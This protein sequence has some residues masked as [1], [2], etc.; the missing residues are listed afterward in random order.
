MP[1]D[2]IPLLCF[3]AYNKTCLTGYTG[4]VSH[5]CNFVI[6]SGI[7]YTHIY[8]ESDLQKSQ[9]HV[10]IGLRTL[11]CGRSKIWSELWQ[12]HHDQLCVSYN[13]MYPQY[14]M[15]LLVSTAA[16][17]QVSHSSCHS[18]ACSHSS[19]LCT[20]VIK[21]E[22]QDSI[23]YYYSRVQMYIYIVT[24]HDIATNMV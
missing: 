13:T 2:R 10:C 6:A 5:M 9:A 24:R 15:S 21:R 3:K 14:R 20:Y 23:K 7:G 16:R 19:Q 1:S 4:S 22:L 12:D 17:H 8:G 18:P 11:L